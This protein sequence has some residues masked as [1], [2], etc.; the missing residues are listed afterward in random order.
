MLEELITSCRGRVVDLRLLA[1]HPRAERTEACRAAM[2]S[3]AAVIIAG[4]LPVDRPGHRVGRR[5]CWCGEPMPRPAARPMTRS[6]VAVEGAA[7]VTDDPMSAGG[8]GGSSL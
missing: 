8:P 2:A 3:G 4:L 7:P 1:E 5:I 6:V